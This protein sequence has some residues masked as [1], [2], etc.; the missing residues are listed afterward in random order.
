MNSMTNTSSPN[1]IKNVRK[2]VSA[3]MGSNFGQKC[4]ERNN[5]FALA[6]KKAL[7]A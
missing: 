7:S 5:A 3:V 6:F 4:L 2:Y 1:R